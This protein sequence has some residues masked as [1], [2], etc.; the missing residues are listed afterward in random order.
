MRKGRFAEVAVDS[1]GKRPE[2]FISGRTKDVRALSCYE[3]GLLVEQYQCNDSI[4]MQKLVLENFFHSRYVL[5][6]N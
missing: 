4:I 2:R 3:F 6:I 1:F 5:F